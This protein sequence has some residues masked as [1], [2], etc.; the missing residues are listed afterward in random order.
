MSNTNGLM[1]AVI[2]SDFPFPGTHEATERSKYLPM[3]RDL[4]PHSQVQSLVSIEWTRLLLYPEFWD[5]YVNRYGA[6]ALIPDAPQ[7]GRLMVWNGDSETG[8]QVNYNNVHIG[9][10]YPTTPDLSPGDQ[11]ACQLAN[12]RRNMQRLARDRLE[13]VVVMNGYTMDPDAPPLQ[14]EPSHQAAGG[15]Q[16]SG[17]SQ[18]QET[19][20]IQ[21]G[22]Q[23]QE[24]P[25]A[26]GA[27][28][29]QGGPQAQEQPP[30]QLQQ[31]QGAPPPAQRSPTPILTYKLPDDVLE[32]LKISEVQAAVQI[33]SQL[34]FFRNVLGLHCIA[35]CDAD[36]L[37]YHLATLVKR[38]LH[39]DLSPEDWGHFL[40]ACNTSKEMLRYV[41]SAS[42]ESAS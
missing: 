22:P 13:A 25:P 38:R 27:P 37:W 21:G 28:Q 12:M 23:A 8:S 33:A 32:P 39:L 30:A 18:A 20:Q 14:G 36:A 2:N 9:L 29:V 1:L 41:M 24:Q 15:P 5:H 26:S 4:V 35:T 19:E 7:A 34:R 10:D 16:A 11:I 31:G 17:A 42:F 40:R 3:G 6:A